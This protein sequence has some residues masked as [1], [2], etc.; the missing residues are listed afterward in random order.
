[1]IEEKRRMLKLK[2][3]KIYK[4]ISECDFAQKLDFFCCKRNILINIV[5]VINVNKMKSR[6][7]FIKTFFNIF[8]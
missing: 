2:S 3:S 6:E 8:I 4:L 7:F 1:M 5:N